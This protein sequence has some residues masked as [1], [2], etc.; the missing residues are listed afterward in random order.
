VCRGVGSFLRVNLNARCVPVGVLERVICPAWKSW[1]P[2][3]LGFGAKSNIFEND[4]LKSRH[5]SLLPKSGVAAS[6]TCIFIY[7]FV[8]DASIGAPRELQVVSGLVISGTG[9][10]QKAEESDRKETSSH[11]L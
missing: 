5:V 9:K 1:Q 10:A 8:D 11:F 2:E 4:Y 3:A 7:G 6:S